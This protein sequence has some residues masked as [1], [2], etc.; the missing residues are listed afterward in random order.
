MTKCL[1]SSHKMVVKYKAL[2]RNTMHSYT[3][4]CT[5]IACITQAQSMEYKHLLGHC[6][7]YTYRDTYFE[8]CLQRPGCFI[9]RHQIVQEYQFS[10]V[11]AVSITYPSITKD[12]VSEE[13]VLTLFCPM[14]LIAFILSMKLT[15]ACHSIVKDNSTFKSR[16]ERC[17]KVCTTDELQPSYPQQITSLFIHWKNISY[18]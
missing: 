15:I 16:A 4:F 10:K 14:V 9:V 7:V 1:N 12:Q 2:L 11:T 5:T 3:Q 6:I 17:N 13:T 8:R 18:V